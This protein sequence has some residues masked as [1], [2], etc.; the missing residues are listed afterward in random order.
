MISLWQKVVGKWRALLSLIEMARYFANWSEVW[1][2]YRSARPLPPLRFRNGWCLQHE[3]GDDPLMLFR[4]IVVHRTYAHPQAAGTV[5]AIVDIGA[6]IGMATLE[7]AARFPDAAIHAY[8]PHPRVFATLTANLEQNRLTGRVRSY[9]EA[10]GATRG[11]CRLH[12]PAETVR[13]SLYPLALAAADVEVPM[14]PLD[15]VVRR[16]GDAAVALLK[17]DAEGAEDA[18]L[19]GASE[20]TLARIRHLV[21][22]YHEDLCPG[23][24]ERCRTLLTRRGFTVSVTPLAPMHGRLLASR[25]T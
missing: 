19:H 18:I 8:E 16:L 12:L 7:L 6:N 24:T 11:A 15:E 21:L 1:G 5:G 2:A 14:V 22:E 3:P 23:V 25:H 20:E 4:E 17:I 10:V 9:A 13:S